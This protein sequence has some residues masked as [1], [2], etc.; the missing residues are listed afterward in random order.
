MTQARSSSVCQNSL[1]AGAL[2]WGPIRISRP[3]GQ[4]AAVARGRRKPLHL[5]PL[6]LKPLHLKCVSRPS[7]YGD[8]HTP[9][10]AGRMVLAGSGPA[11][12]A[13]RRPSPERNL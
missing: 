1:G 8:H 13:G 3:P 12:E 9:D 2:Y 10:L 7:S 11:A 4:L 6:H 5:K